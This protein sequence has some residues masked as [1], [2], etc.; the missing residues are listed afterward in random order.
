MHIALLRRRNRRRPRLQEGIR[1]ACPGVL[2]RHRR[3]MSK[4]KGRA[5]YGPF[6]STHGPSIGPSRRFG[7]SRA[8]CGLSLHPAEF[9]S[10][11]FPITSRVVHARTLVHR[12]GVLQATYLATMSGNG[13]GRRHADRD[14]AV[15][16]SATLGRE[17]YQWRPRVPK[18]S[19]ARRAM[20]QPVGRVCG[21]ARSVAIE[22]SC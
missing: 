17:N 22:M 21:P 20:P 14:R 4:I 12:A 3:F 9:D 5:M 15:N 7:L 18:A 6:L 8:C 1:A 11:G 2:G 10:H 19:S 16:G 13:E